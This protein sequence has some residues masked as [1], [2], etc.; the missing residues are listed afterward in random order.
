ML[1]NKISPFVRGEVSFGAKL[2]QSATP[3]ACELKFLNT[4]SISKN[5]LGKMSAATRRI[6]IFPELEW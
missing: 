3:S 1:L 4:K 5:R 2:L 6:A